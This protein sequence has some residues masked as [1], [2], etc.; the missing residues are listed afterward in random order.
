MNLEIGLT[1]LLRLNQQRQAKRPA[2][3]VQTLILSKKRF[4]SAKA[5]SKWVRDNGFKVH[6]IDETSTSYRF[7]Q[8]EPSKFIKGSF[9]TITLTTGV[10]AVVGRLKKKTNRTTIKFRVDFIARQDDEQIV[11]GI[12]ADASNVDSF[13]NRV[14]RKEVWRAAYR[15]MELYRNMGVS[16]SR[17]GKGR[18]IILND[19]IRILESWVTREK[20]TLDGTSVPVDAWL[21]TVRINDSKIWRAVKD[22]K[23][24]GFSFE[25]NAKRVPLAAVKE[26]DN[27][28]QKAA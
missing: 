19:K 14:P 6:K 7:R 20:T 25:A 26:T 15:F 28:K 23:L 22:K 1:E 8:R 12:V 10:K 5:A 27:A 11:T 21:L 24:T 13:K 3:T 16:H 2:T 18:P 17:D 4:K 9:R